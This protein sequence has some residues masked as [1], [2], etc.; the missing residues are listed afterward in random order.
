[1]SRK[2]AR[3]EAFKLLY[4]INIQKGNENEII[5]T[6][7]NEHDVD[8]KDQVFIQDVVSGTLQNL[9][10]ID[11]HIEKNTVKW[12]VNR[13]SKVNIAILRIAIF[14][15]LKRPD[16]PMSVSINEAV[17]LSKKYD[18]EKSGAF[19]NGILASIKKQLQPEG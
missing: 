11:E 19:V 12:K 9:K 3:E 5:E 4:Q 18:S 1:M 6:Y 13:I 14:E 7:F 17:E 8:A 2:T 10:E 16:I 15:M